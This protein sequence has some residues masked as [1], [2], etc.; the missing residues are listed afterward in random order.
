MSARAAAS[1]LDSTT[2]SG[3]LVGAIQDFYGKDKIP[4][5]T[6]TFNDWVDLLEESTAQMEGNAMWL[7]RNPGVK[8]IDTYRAMA[9]APAEAATVYDMTRTV[10]RS[11]AMAAAKAVTPELM[12]LWSAEAGW[13]VLSMS[14]VPSPPRSIACWPLG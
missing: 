10:S 8:L 6:A 7:E 13:T 5:V 4:R 9:S 11:P 2:W 3:S 1:T 14:T 12:K